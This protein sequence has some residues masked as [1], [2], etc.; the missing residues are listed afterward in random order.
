MGEPVLGII[1]DNCDQLLFGEL[2]KKFY[3]FVTFLCTHITLRYE[4][5][6][7]GVPQGVP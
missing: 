2:L 4:L 7:C 3:P 1:D 6:P 5:T